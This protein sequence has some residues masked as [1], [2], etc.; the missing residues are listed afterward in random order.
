MCSSDLAFETPSAPLPISR[1]SEFG[2]FDVQA[3]SR[4]SAAGFDGM[5]AQHGADC[6]APPA[7]HF[8]QSF[9]DSVFI[10]N[11]HVM[12]AANAGGYGMIAL[13]PSQLL[14]CSAGCSVQWDMSTERMSLRDW[15]D[16]WLTPWADNLTLPFSED[17]GSVDLQGPPRQGVRVAANAGRNAWKVTTIGGYNETPLDTAWWVDMDSGITA[18]TNQA[19]VRQTFKLTITPGHVR[20]ERLASATATAIV[21]VDA[22]APVL[23]APDYVVQFAQHS[24]NPF[25]DGAGVAATWH[26]SGFELNPSTPFTLIKGDRS[27]TANGTVVF[28]QPAPANAYLRFTGLCK[29]SVDGVVATK[30]RVLRVGSAASYF[31]PIKQGKQSVNISFANDDWY[32]MNFGCRA[33]GFSIWSK[34]GGSPSTPT[35]AS[36]PTLTP[37]TATPAATL[38]PTSTASPIPPTATSSPVSS[39]TPTAIVPTATP[40]P[41]STP[42]P[43]TYTCLANGTP[44]WSQAAPGRACP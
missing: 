33:Q 18:G 19:A 27:L 23:L 28:A 2:H 14:N 31:I 3:H 37:S 38:P 29:V 9:E 36:T 11:G 25:K 15:P 32:T 16:V 30:Q 44:V 41:T 21:W 10:C 43:T 34:T 7:T 4:D 12:T 5:A 39:P 22:N 42:Q 6:A 40:S 24:Y 35:P 26:W 8:V 1:S 17:V 13:T 20:F